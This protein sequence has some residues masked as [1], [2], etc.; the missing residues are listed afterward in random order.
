MIIMS[1][2]VVIFRPSDAEGLTRWGWRFAQASNRDLVILSVEKGVKAT[3][4][5]VVPMDDPQH[6]LRSDPVV[7]KALEVLEEKRGLESEQPSPSN[8]RDGGVEVRHLVHADL[9]RGV[10]REIEQCDARLLVLGGRSSGHGRP[11]G[12][13]VARRLFQQ[14]SCTALLL[15]LGSTN[16]ESCQR[17]LV[18]AA[19]GEHSQEA[20]RWAGQCCDSEGGSFVSLFVES[21]SGEEAQEVGERILDR[22]LGEAG[23]QGHPN[24]EA[25]VELAASVSEGISKVAEEGYDLVLMGASH[26]SALR[27]KL[28]KTVPERLVAKQGGVTLGVLRVAQP[29]VSWWR[30]ALANLLDFSIPQLEREDRVALVENLQLQSRWSFDFMALIGLSTAI[31]SLGLLQDSAAVVIGAMLVAPLM[32]PLLGAGLA[33]VQGNLPLMRSAA[34]AIVLGF[35]TAL[36]IGA[37]LGALVPLPSLSSELAARGQPT[38]LD[39]GVAFLSGIAAAHCVGRPNLS[40]ALPG[41]AI[42]AALVPPIAT[43]GISL[44]LGDLENARGSAILFGVNVVA[45]ILGAASSFFAAGIRSNRS[46]RRGNRWARAMLAAL[47]LVLVALIVPL[48]SFLVAQITPMPRISFKA[49]GEMRQEVAERLSLEPEVQLVDVE[50]RHQ[51]GKNL[52]VLRL[53]ASSPAGEV[54]VSDLATIAARQLGAAVEVRVHTE[55]VKVSRA[56]AGTGEPSASKPANPTREPNPETESGNRIR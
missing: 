55:L 31:A 13:G 49:S 24:L 33:L 15:R 3:R 7:S 30:R 56:S 28:F 48:A 16:G 29:A 50:Q 12:S 4:S 54:L 10:L 37:A 34:Q 23:L 27:Q 35:L 26:S 25:R 45:V 11:E 38:L 41:V 22:T 39:L 17:I 21:D 2:L 14:A 1:V 36:A 47:A 40:A 43:I 9:C 46:L 32:T 42:A 44:A 20:L 19:G 8:S 53:T 5:T 52:V 6:P 51:E 18:P